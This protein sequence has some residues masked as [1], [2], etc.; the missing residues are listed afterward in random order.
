MQL[1]YQDWENE[2]KE[3]DQELQAKIRDHRNSG[4]MCSPDCWC[5]SAQGTICLYLSAIEANKLLLNHNQQ[6]RKEACKQTFKDWLELECPDKSRS[7]LQEMPMELAMVIC[8]IEGTKR[9]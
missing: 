1:K 5:W 7:I 2:M 9:C 6:L 8:W 3:C 4:V